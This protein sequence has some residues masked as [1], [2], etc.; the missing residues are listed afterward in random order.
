MTLNTANVCTTLRSDLLWFAEAFLWLALVL[1]LLAAAA[2]LATKL[3]PLLNQP[4]FPASRSAASTDPVKLLDAL[5]G[6]I[7]VIAKA[8]TWIAAFGAAMA[9]AWAAGSLVPSPCWT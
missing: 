6:L 1:A 3:A 9:L 7:D 8:P 5:K 2:D 4:T